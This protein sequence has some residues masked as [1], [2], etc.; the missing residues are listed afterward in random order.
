MK[1][2]IKYGMSFEKFKE[3]LDS[4]KLGDIHSYPLE[5]DAMLWED[6]VKEKQLRLVSLRRLEQLS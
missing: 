5:K 3:D 2:E 4:G 1:L 6:I